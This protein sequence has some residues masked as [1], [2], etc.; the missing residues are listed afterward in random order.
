M[1]W[2]NVRFVSTKWFG[3]IASRIRQ[4]LDNLLSKEW[5]CNQKLEQAAV[6][7]RVLN[8]KHWLELAI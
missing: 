6:E 8:S 3:L 1:F 2:I 5:S 4:Q 7:Q